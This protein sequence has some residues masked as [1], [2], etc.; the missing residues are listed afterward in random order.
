MLQARFTGFKCGFCH[1]AWEEKTDFALNTYNNTCQ[2]FF[3]K[4]VEKCHTEKEI[5]LTET[6][7]TAIENIFKNPLMRYPIQETL[8]SNGVNFW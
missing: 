6:P 8:L 2:E 7:R 4:L 3:Y 1:G 5:N